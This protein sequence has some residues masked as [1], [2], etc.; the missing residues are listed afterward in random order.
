MNKV[1][2]DAM[3]IDEVPKVSSLPPT[4]YD[5][6]MSSNLSSSTSSILQKENPMQKSLS[7]SVQNSK[8]LYDDIDLPDIDDELSE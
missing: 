8:G 4:K 5:L 1:Q 6:A 2:E 3:D 7:S